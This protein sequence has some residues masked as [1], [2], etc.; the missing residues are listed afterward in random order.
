MVEKEKVTEAF[1]AIR[2]VS[3]EPNGT[4]VKT[5][6]SRIF[7]KNYECALD[8]S[9]RPLETVIVLTSEEAVKVA[10]QINGIARYKLLEC[11]SDEKDEGK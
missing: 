2:Q 7:A 5:I 3:L 6:V 8:I 1:V 10:S 11:C 4:P 9:S